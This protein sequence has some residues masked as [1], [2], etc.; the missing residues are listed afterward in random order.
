MLSCRWRDRIL[1]SNILYSTYRIY[2]VVPTDIRRRGGP[3]SFPKGWEILIVSWDW[4]FVL[5]DLSYVVS[6]GGP[7]IVLTTHSVYYIRGSGTR[8][9]QRSL[10]F[11]MNDFW[12]FWWP[13]ISGDRCSLIFPNMCLTVDKKPRKIPN[14]EIGP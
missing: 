6:G 1:L 5:C 10:E 4:M 2:T 7:Y 12:W 14:N 11:I 13:M 3:G 8:P 9:H